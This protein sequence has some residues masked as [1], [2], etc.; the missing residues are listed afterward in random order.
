MVGYWFRLEAAAP[1]GGEAVELPVGSAVHQKW[2]RLR[3]GHAW[4]S[5]T[6]RARGRSSAHCCFC[7]QAIARLPIVRVIAALPVL[8][9][10]D[11]AARSTS[12]RAPPEQG[13]WWPVGSSVD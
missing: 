13:P 3:S 7:L 10:C 1:A 6:A 2:L 12:L 5:V 9:R 4:T 11:G 8:V